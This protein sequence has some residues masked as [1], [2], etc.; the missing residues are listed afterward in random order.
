[1]EIK[2]FYILLLSVLPI[3]ELRG[4]LPLGIVYALENEIP[5]WLISLNV[6]LLNVLVTFFVFYFLDKVHKKLI[7][8]R[9]YENLFNRYVLSVQNKLHRIKN[10]RR[11]SFIALMLL[12]AVPLPGTGAWSGC[13]ASWLLG[14]ERKKSVLAISLGVLIAGILILLGTLGFINIVK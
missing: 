7:K 11:G 6:I 4:G 3:F 9:I 13:L 5:I 12:V 1:M 8:V 14:L 10:S 2:L